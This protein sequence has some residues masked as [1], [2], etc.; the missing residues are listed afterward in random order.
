[1]NKIFAGPRAP[2]NLWEI[3][4]RIGIAPLNC[5]FN[6]GRD[7][8]AGRIL[9]A[10]TFIG[11]YRTHPGTKTTLTGGS[12]SSARRSGRGTVI[13]IFLWPAADDSP[14]QGHGQVSL[15]LI[16]DEPCHGLDIPI[17]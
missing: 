6:T 4:K 8:R 10:F 11:L 16:V 2:G 5:R 7:E 12:K 3:K 1:M 14:C 15:L 9:R 17:G 13:I